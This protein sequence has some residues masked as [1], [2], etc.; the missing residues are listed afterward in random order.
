VR[1]ELRHADVVTCI[2]AAG[3]ISAAAASMSAVVD[4]LLPWRRSR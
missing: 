1:L 4:A 2:A 3:S